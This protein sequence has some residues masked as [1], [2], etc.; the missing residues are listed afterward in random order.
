MGILLVSKVDSNLDA[1]PG[2][3][4]LNPEASES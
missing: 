3:F 2:P 1:G 4:E